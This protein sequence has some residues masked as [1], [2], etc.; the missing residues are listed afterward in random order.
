MTGPTRRR[1]LTG[2]GAG[3]AALAGCSGFPGTG[4]EDEGGRQEYD[5]EAL[6]EAL[7][8][9]ESVL[10]PDDFPVTLPASLQNAHRQRAREYLDR[11][12]AEPSFPNEAM[13]AKLAEQRREALSDLERDATGRPRN[14]LETWRRRRVEAATVSGAYVAANGD[15]DR[16]GVADGRNQVRSTLASFEAD[17]AY[18]ATDPVAAAVVHGTL[19]GYVEECREKLISRHPFPEDPTDDVFRA[20]EILGELNGANASLVDAGRMRRQ[21]RHQTD[22]TA[23]YRRS[24]SAAAA[25]LR[26]SLSRTRNDLKPDAESDTDAFDRDLEGTPAAHLFRDATRVLDWRSDAAEQAGRRHAPAT[27]TLEAG[28]AL[29]AAGALE[30]VV[31]AIQDGRYQNQPSVDDVEA[32]SQRALDA[33]ETAWEATPNSLAVELARPVLLSLRGAA[34]RV[35]EGYAGP[36]RAL[37]TLVLAEAQARAVPDATTFVARRLQS[38]ESR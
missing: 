21:Y 27:A 24:L 14:R 38:G 28:R 29:V 36:R 3:L 5:E 22:E 30:A 1:L 17:W 35:N 11:V 4:G 2:C 20:G 34:S 18:R 12:P 31:A 37:A 9:P 23:A 32:A 26:R 25:R 6:A 16:V 7:G 33:L 15:V 10:P 13:A 19:E 8:V